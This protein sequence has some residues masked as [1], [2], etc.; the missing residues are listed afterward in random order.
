[1]RQIEIWAIAATVVMFAS[2]CA[3]DVEEDDDDIDDT[4]QALENDDV[5]QTKLCARVK[6]TT[7]LYRHPTGSETPATASRTGATLTTEGGLAYVL[8]QRQ[9]G[10]VNG[11]VWVDPDMWGLTDPTVKADVDSVARRCRLKKRSQAR[12]VMA[13]A[14]KD[15]FKRRGW[16]KVEDLDN[17]PSD[18]KERRSSGA[19]AQ[20]RDFDPSNDDKLRD[21]RVMRVK[22]SCVV[23][24]AY[25]G[26]DKNNPTGMRSYGTCLVID[27]DDG[28][29]AKSATEMY[30]SYNTP[31]INHGGMT[32]SYVEVGAPV[33]VL[34]LNTHE[35]VGDHCQRT[36]REAGARCNGD[37]NVPLEARAPIF[38]WA[39]I[40]AKTGRDGRL[41]RGFVPNECLE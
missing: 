37:P 31:E 4:Q 28:S 25:K 18:M 41:I 10:Q 34:R 38:R 32:F 19:K 17:L 26:S 11:R 8:V 1:M 30:V 6:R 35:Q 14:K 23:N 13:N 7:T 16:V 15:A 20:A 39:E 12:E 21:G 29:C 33:H 40:W 22:G 36:G 27:K 9:P 3:A 5:V 24:A 2:G